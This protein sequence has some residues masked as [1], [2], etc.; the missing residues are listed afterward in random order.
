MWK[1]SRRAGLI[2]ENTHEEIADAFP[3]GSLANKPRSAFAAVM[4][5]EGIAVP[6]AS[7]ILTALDRVRDTV[8]R[9]VVGGKGLKH[10]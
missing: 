2:A 3:L 4:G 5:L 1:S 7:A 8:H 9:G 10:N 6:M